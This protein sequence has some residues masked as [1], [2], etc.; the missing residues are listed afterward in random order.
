MKRLSRKNWARQATASRQGTSPIF[1][2]TNN[3]TQWDECKQI[4]LESTKDSTL[5]SLIRHAQISHVRCLFFKQGQTICST[6]CRYVRNIM[7]YSYRHNKAELLLIM[8][9]KYLS[10][11]VNNINYC[12]IICHLSFDSLNRWQHMFH[13]VRTRS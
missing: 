5:H 2:R 10:G 12:N 11:I 9:V 1:T 8:Q 4:S 6:L 13:F 7:Q 3:V